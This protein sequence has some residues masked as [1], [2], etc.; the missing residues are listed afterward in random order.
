MENSDS[1]ISERENQALNFLQRDFDQC[2]Q[3]LRHYDT[4]IFNILKFT[5]TAYTV[6]I[7]A[8]LG[9]YQFG[10]KEQVDITSPVTAV[11][12]VGTLLGLFMFVL[13]IR[14]RVYFVKIARYLNEQ[15]GLYHHNITIF[16]YDNCSR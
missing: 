13:V 6:L 11:L 8:A 10:L 5:F 14:N 7:G 12:I 1:N 15:R 3:Q 2:F 4:Q 16:L 9:L